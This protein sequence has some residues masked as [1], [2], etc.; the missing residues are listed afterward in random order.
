MNQPNTAKSGFERRAFGRRETLLPAVVR[1]N[2]R[3]ILSCTVRDVSEGG[4]LLEFPEVAELPPRIRLTI[5]GSVNEIICDV[6]HQR[7]NRAGV[8]FACGP[9]AIA[10]RQIVVP[11]DPATRVQHPAAIDERFT[12]TGGGPQVAMQL[13]AQ[14]RK[15]R[16]IVRDDEAVALIVAANDDVPRDM[17]ALI[18][19]ISMAEAAQPAAGPPREMAASLFR[20][21]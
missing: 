6:R 3:T 2:Q 20:Q 4:A 9:M 21:D 16:A 5:G 10:L 15:A 18:K 11:A 17:S 12:D 7:E 8:Q 13:I 19:S 1:I 14:L